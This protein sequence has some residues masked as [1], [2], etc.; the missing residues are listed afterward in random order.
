MPKPGAF[1]VRFKDGVFEGTRLIEDQRWPPP[2]EIDLGI[3]NGKYVQ[4]SISQLTE[5]Q[6][7]GSPY[8]MRGAEYEWQGDC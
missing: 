2:D 6:V 4:V 5:E 3:G 1:L 7:A 8:I